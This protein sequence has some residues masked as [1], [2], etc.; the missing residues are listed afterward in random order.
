[1]VNLDGQHIRPIQ[2]PRGIELWNGMKLLSLVAGVHGITARVWWG[3][4]AGRHVIV[5]PF[6]C[7]L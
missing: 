1:M 5:P 6:V 2:E 4:V 3:D 7:A